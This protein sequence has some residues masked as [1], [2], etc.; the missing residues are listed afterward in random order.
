[1]ANTQ[2]IKRNLCQD[3]PGHLL[4]AQVRN[5]N[6]RTNPSWCCAGGICPLG[7]WSDTTGLSRKLKHF[8]WMCN[9]RKMFLLTVFWGGNTFGGTS[10]TSWQWRRT[11]FFCWGWYMGICTQQSPM[12]NRG[13]RS[14]RCWRRSP[15][16][17]VL[18]TFIF[19]FKVSPMAAQKVLDAES[20]G[21]DEDANL[22]HVFCWWRLSRGWAKSLIVP[23]IVA[24][25]LIEPH[26]YNYWIEAVPYR[27]RSKQNL[28]RVTV[29]SV[30]CLLVLQSGNQFHTISHGFR[31]AAA[32]SLSSSSKLFKIW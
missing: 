12:V 16:S 28:A 25:L 22:H 19:T 23:R 5:R 8:G 6:F 20:L 7:S 15:P 30:R 11:S 31:I 29:G 13:L 9:I 3:L 32:D 26:L 14:H 10:R 1:M 2:I 17:F 18:L 21:F 4:N 27:C 24:F